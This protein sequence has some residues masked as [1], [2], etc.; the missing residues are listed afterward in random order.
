MKINLADLSISL[1]AVLILATSCTS[2]DPEDATLVEPD[3]REAGLSIRDEERACTDDDECVLLPFDGCCNCN[4]GG[5]RAAAHQN[6][7][8]AV[9]ERQSEAC[10]M[11]AC[12]TVISTHETCVNEVV[13]KCV[14]QKCELVIK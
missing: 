9:Q 10:E 12:S 1:F 6:Q 11:L 14:E 5:K 8:D 3:Q 4:H 7:L 2:T 13:P